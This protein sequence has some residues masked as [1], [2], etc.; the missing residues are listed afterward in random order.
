MALIINGHERSKVSLQIGQSPTWRTWAYVTPRK[1][2]A[3][4]KLQV[5]VV[6]DQGKTLVEE[7]LP[8]ELGS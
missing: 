6:D 2:D 8:I 7:I 1:E 5:K 4:G 3:P